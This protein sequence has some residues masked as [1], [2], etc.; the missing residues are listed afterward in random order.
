MFSESCGAAGVAPRLRAA[1]CG[2]AFAA[3]ERCFAAIRTRKPSARFAF[4]IK[5]FEIGVLGVNLGF[6]G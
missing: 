4:V 3:N 2:N 6:C 1:S 5:S